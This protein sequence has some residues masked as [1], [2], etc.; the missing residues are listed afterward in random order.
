MSC[1]ATPWFLN[2]FFPARSAAADRLDKRFVRQD[3]SHN[4][5]HL[6]QIVKIGQWP[7]APWLVNVAAQADTQRALAVTAREKQKLKN[8]QPG[9]RL[10]LADH[11]IAPALWT[12]VVNSPCRAGFRQA[13]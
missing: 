11:P 9:R 1:L 5:S 12:G 2:A 6:P 10:E 4:F 8:G 13:C 3:F 7:A